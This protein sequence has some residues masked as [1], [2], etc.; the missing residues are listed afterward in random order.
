[1]RIHHGPPAAFSQII[2][3]AAF[4][5]KILPLHARHSVYFS[6]FFFFDLRIFRVASNHLF[7]SA[8][9]D[10][11]RLD[12]RTPSKRAVCPH[13]PR[14]A[15]CRRSRDRRFRELTADQQVFCGGLL[16]GVYWPALN[17]LSI[18][19]YQHFFTVLAID[20]ELFRNN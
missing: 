16:P 17:L 18:V 12:L 6:D 11:G 2:L 15:N 3:F 4:S 10:D 5:A 20:A 7:S 19:N 14:S 1:M 9:T 8:R 13:E